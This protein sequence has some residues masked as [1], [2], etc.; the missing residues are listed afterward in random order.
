MTPWTLPR[1][2]FAL[3]LLLARGRPQ[4]VKQCRIDCFSRALWSLNRGYCGDRLGTFGPL[5]ERVIG[6]DTGFLLGSTVLPVAVRMTRLFRGLKAC[7][8]V[9]PSVISRGFERRGREGE[10]GGGDTEEILPGDCPGADPP[11]S[12][13]R[14]KLALR[15][16]ATSCSAWRWSLFGCRGF[17]EGW[18]W[19]PAF[20]LFP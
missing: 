5:L 1:P 10:S 11:L 13:S 18:S 12:G 14:K 9:R 19:S 6:W 7:V 16:P 3:S 8:V 2:R 15:S 4:Q 20:W 17:L